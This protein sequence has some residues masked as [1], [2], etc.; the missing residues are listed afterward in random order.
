MLNLNKYYETLETALKQIEHIKAKISD[1]PR[2]ALNHK[3]LKIWQR[4][5]IN[6]EMKIRE[7]GNNQPI[8]IVEFG[9]YT[10]E[11]LNG[12]QYA[13]TA[14]KKVTDTVYYP[15]HDKDELILL[16]KRDF[17]DVLPLAETK[18]FTGKSK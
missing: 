13:M 10:S 1:N 5:K 7:L 15:T 3:H 17:G 8:T 6:A 16:I 14:V 18:V 11:P 9:F 4:N 12:S 2:N